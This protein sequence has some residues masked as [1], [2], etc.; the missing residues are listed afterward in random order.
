MAVIW[1]I[2]ATLVAAVHAQTWHEDGDAPALLPGQTTGGPG[3]LTTIQ[4]SLSSGDDVD[5]YAI[6]IDDPANFSVES[7]GGTSIDSTL[8]LFDENGNGVVMSE[9]GC[10]TQSQITNQFVTTTGLYY[11]AMSAYDYDPQNADGLEIWNDAPWGEEHA[12]DGPGAPGPLAGW[13]GS[14]VGSGAYA[15]SLTGAS[16]AVY[17]PPPATGGCCYPNGSCQVLTAAGCNAIGGAYQ[18]DDTTC[19]PNLCPEPELGAC[20]FFT[21]GCLALLE[22]DCIDN[23]GTFQGA[24]TMCWPDPCAGGEPPSQG[25]SDNFDSYENGTVMYNVGGWSGWDDNPAAA[26]IITNLQSRSAPHSIMANDT[27]DAVHPLSGFEGGKWIITAWQYL[28]SNLSGMSYFVVNSYYSPNDTAFW[29]VELHFDPV[30]GKVNDALRDQ[31]ASQTVPIV[32]DQWVEIRIE[33]DLTGG[34]GTIAQYYNG[35]LVFAGDWIAGAIGQLAIGNIDLYAPHGTPVF[36]DDISVVPDEDV[37]EPSTPVRPLFAG[38][39]YGDQRTRTTSLQGDPVTWNSGFQASVEGAA[40]RPDGA[41]YFTE[42]GFQSRLYLAPIEGPPIE[43]CQLPFTVSGLAYGRGRLFGY[44]NSG[45]SI[46]E[47]NPDTCATALFLGTSPRMYFGLDYNP[48][49]DKLYG[50]TEYGSP[51]GLYAI[52]L[53]TGEQ[54]HVAPPFPADNSAGRGVACGDNKV[55]VLPV[56]GEYPLYYYDLDTGTWHPLAHPFPESS[57]AGGLAW[58]AAPKPGDFNLDGKID[59][60][61]AGEFAEC[62]TGPGVEPLPGC[63]IADLSVDEDVDLY[64]Y[65]IMMGLFHP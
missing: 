44:T 40:G 1:V 55:F 54:T 42:T 51:T 28:P 2:A 48:V 6:L 16:F 64:D 18:G 62:L 31:S 19:E 58:V 26:G 10:G 7:C 65:A 25:W 56:Y 59:L 38:L 15:L 17:A 50:Y 33:A 63:A 39:A 45:T 43:L 21:N 13:G 60:S 41:V 23:G 11:V 14:A 30:T 27:V 22:S 8:Y 32:F 5:L 57:S 29:V 34:L 37:E 3:T 53:D 12:A 4:G 49:D 36:Y 52:D 61:D 9:D 20:C 46:Y 47:I 24:D 35:Q